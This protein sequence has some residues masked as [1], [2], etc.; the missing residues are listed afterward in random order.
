MGWDVVKSIRNVEDQP[1]AFA[2]GIITLE[3]QGVLN[4]VLQS[5]EYNTFP[6]LH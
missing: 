2:S 4:C 6:D 1:F 5:G 3:S